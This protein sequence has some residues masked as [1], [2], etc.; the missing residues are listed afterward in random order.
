MEKSS[1]D[2]FLRCRECQRLLDIRDIKE[3]HSCLCSCKSFRS[4]KY[5]LNEE[6]YNRIKKAAPEFAK[7]FE[8]VEEAD[9]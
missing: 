8:P 9:G 1:V 3:R 2:P 4:V 6:E 5:L 7:I